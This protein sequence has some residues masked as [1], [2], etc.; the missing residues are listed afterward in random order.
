MRLFDS[1]CHLQDE[2]LAPHLDGVLSRAADAGVVAM[3][4]C[5]S[6]ESDWEAV[7]QLARS[8]PA[9]R[10]AFGLHP[11]YVAGRSPQWIET[12]RSFLTGSRGRS[13]SQKTETSSPF[14]RASVPA[15]RASTGE[16]QPEQTD[17]SSVKPAVGEIGLDHALDKATFAAQEECFLAQ[18]QLA[19]E[20]HRPVSL[21]CR[22]A[23]GRLM[24][25]LD[26]HGWPPD[27]VILH[28]YSGG[29][30]LIAPLARRG[31]YFSFSGAITHERNSRG[32][33]AAA[34]V[35][36]DR[37]LI[38]SDAPDIPAALAPDAP[39][40]RDTEGKPLSEPANLLLTLRTLAALR[41]APE[42]SLANAIWENANRIQ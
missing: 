7:R 28:S 14:G 15:S 23:W 30:E 25:L 33:E 17:A 4:C 35:P 31:A 32:R 10:P 16:Q 34:D 20:F 39:C 36:E 18:I 40:L 21:H 3:L 42:D 2:R 9:I 19:A 12:L 41:H 38:E 6:A 13:P 27:G 1:H 29:R 8:N 11:W 24:D 37:L 5:G 26:S 22:R